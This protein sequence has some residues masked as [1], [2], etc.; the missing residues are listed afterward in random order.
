MKLPPYKP[1]HP[2][3]KPPRPPSSAQ[4]LQIAWREYIP[5]LALV[6]VAM[7]A[8]SAKDASYGPDGRPLRWMHD[9]MGFFLI[10][11]ALLK[12]FDLPGFADGFQKYDLL[13]KRSRRYALAYPFIELALGLGYLALWQP[14]KVYVATMIVLGLGTLGVISALAKGLDV[15]CACMGSALKV[16]LST[17]ALVEDITMFA[18]A[19]GLW[20][21]LH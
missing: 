11:F 14:P 8:A 13:A 9:F 5:L 15:K 3:P 10:F 6:A 2:Q 16:P 4:A 21:R 7:L 1:P 17:V 19:A 20:L 18:M 12:L